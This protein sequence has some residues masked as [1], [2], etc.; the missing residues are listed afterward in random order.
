MLCCWQEG[1]SNAILGL[2]FGVVSAPF[3]VLRSILSELIW[4]WLSS[5]STYSSAR[6]PGETFSPLPRKETSPAKGLVDLGITCI[7]RASWVSREDHKPW[8]FIVLAFFFYYYFFSREERQESCTKGGNIEQEMKM[9]GHAWQMSGGGRWASSA[10][11][12]I[13]L[14]FSNLGWLLHAGKCTNWPFLVPAI[15]LAYS[16]RL[17]QNVVD[18]MQCWNNSSWIVSAGGRESCIITLLSLTFKYS[19]ISPLLN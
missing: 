9:S 10:L 1:P 2:P 5:P 15:C 6:S 4:H 17:C 8:A 3:L 14:C 13:S 19:S 12:N 18:A 16:T 11:Q 7:A